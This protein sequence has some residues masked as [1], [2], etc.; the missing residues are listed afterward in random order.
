[1]SIPVKVLFVLCSSLIILSLSACKKVGPA[2]R[3]G[4]NIDE[5][6]GK[7]G[8]QIDRS[9]DKAAEKLEETGKKL[10]DSIHK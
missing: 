1:M 3:A 8:K 2:E 6:V 9:T 5:A 4:R 10:K 7:A